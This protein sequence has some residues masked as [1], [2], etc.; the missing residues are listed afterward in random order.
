MKNKKYVAPQLSATNVD[1]KDIMTLSV[2]FGNDDL[3][4]WANDP[5]GKI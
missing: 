3:D 1:T 5:F 4:N 2:I